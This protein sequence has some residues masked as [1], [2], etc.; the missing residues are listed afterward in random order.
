[1]T[2]EDVADGVDPRQPPIRPVATAAQYEAAIQRAERV[3]RG[4]KSRAWVLKILREYIAS[5]L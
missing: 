4:N 2:V 5:T 3:F 1:M